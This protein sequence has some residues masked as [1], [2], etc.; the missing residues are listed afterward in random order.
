MD[1]ELMTVEEI[2]DRLKM[3]P[4]SVRRWL[5]EGS[6]LG[7]RISRAAG[8]RVERREVDR[9]LREGPRRKENERPD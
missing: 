7:V 9:F 3:H 6:M 2:A 5:R 4:E 8:W 1:D